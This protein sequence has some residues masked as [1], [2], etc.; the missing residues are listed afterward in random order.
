M[1]FERSFGQPEVSFH[2]LQMISIYRLHAYTFCF[3]LQIQRERKSHL[4]ALSRSAE[5]PARNGNLLGRIRR[6]TQRRQAHAFS[7]TRLELL[8]VPQHRHFTRFSRR[9]LGH[10]DADQ[11]MLLFMF[12]ESSS[13]KRKVKEKNAMR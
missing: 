4:E 2:S 8:A 3:L 6:Q 13:G 11:K 9:H 12:E 1:G 10:Q 5:T 7:G